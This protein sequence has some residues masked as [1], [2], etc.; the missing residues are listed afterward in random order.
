MFQKLLRF[1]GPRHS[2]NGKFVDADPFSCHSIKDS[3]TQT[4]FRIMVFN[5]D[6]GV[7]RLRCRLLERFL[8]N[9]LDGIQIYNSDSDPCFSEYVVG[10][11]RFVKRNTCSN[12]GHL[13]FTAFPNN[14][15]P[16]NRETLISIVK[17]GGFWTRGAEV[18]NT[19]IS[20][21]F[22]DEPFSGNCIAWIQHDCLWNRTEHRDVL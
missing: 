11:Q 16:T 15:T 21:G 18:N 13:I 17:N 4:A 12:N 7:V 3:I 9:R 20:R 1:P 6:E 2:C 14:F 19:F 10:F 8:I 22:R 5:G